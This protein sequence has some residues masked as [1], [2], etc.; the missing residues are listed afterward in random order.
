MV[1]EL[2]GTQIVGEGLVEMP[3]VPLDA[4]T[5]QP[6]GA[7]AG[8]DA[9]YGIDIGKC[10]GEL[11]APAKKFGAQR[12][13]GRERILPV[14][15]IEPRKA[16]IRC[17]RLRRVLQQG[18]GLLRI[19]QR[20][21]R[22]SGVMPRQRPFGKR[23]G[24]AAIAANGCI[25]I[26]YGK[27]RPPRIVI[28]DRPVRQRPR[29]AR[30]FAEHRVERRQGAHIVVRQQCNLGLLLGGFSGTRRAGTG[31]NKTCSK[32]GK[33][34]LHRMNSFAAVGASNTYRGRKSIVAPIN[35][36]QFTRLR[37]RHV[38]EDQF[39]RG[40]K[41]SNQDQNGNGKKRPAA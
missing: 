7:V 22:L 38:I 25:E 19:L 3:L 13:R 14:R 31:T 4:A 24:R 9:K 36:R 28:H 39:Q 37:R 40:P 35:K 41:D 18:N 23:E 26:G 10:R 17:A 34:Q 33:Q 15:G 6:G 8:I 20:A 32:Q 30:M 12:V 21:C 11:L 5:D 27:I 29:I 1:V 16:R 2:V